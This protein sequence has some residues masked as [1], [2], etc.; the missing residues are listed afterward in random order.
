MQMDVYLDISNFWVKKYRVAIPHSKDYYDDLY[1][2]GKT[3][4][5]GSEEVSNPLL[6]RT[7]SDY[8]YSGQ[9]RAWVVG[10]RFML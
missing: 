8:L 1:A 10:F 6:L 3:N 2:N 7:R 4:R 5:V 9:Y